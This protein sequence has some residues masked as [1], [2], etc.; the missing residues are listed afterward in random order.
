MRLVLALAVVCACG[1]PGHQRLGDT[2]AARHRPVPYEAPAASTSD[3]D[4]EQL[5][6]SFDDM[7]RTQRAYEEAGKASAPPPP[8][9]TAPGLPAE[10]MLESNADAKP[11]PKPTPMRMPRRH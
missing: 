8:L 9:P 2:Q 11:D 7:S 6:Q 10:P 1:G 4:R 5:I 3:K